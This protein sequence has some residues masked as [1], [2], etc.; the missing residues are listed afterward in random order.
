V[1]TRTRYVELVFFPPMGYA[2]H[3][4]HSG[5][6]VTQNIN[7]IFFMLG[8]ARYRFL[9]KGVRTRDTELVL[10]HLVGYAG[11]VV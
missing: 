9:K 6:S 5:A 11:H 2:G 4:V 1:R 7:T 8:W 10:L 3:I